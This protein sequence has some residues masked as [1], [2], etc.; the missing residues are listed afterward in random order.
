MQNNGYLDVKQQVKLL[1]KKGI[2]IT[3]QDEEILNKVNYYTIMSYKNIFYVDGIIHQYKKGIS[4]KD[5]YS[6]Y[7]LDNE[8]KD[9]LLKKFRILTNKFSVRLINRFCEYYGYLED[10]YLNDDLYNKMFIKDYYISLLSND[11]V[12]DYYDI[13]GFIPLWIIINNMSFRDLVEYIMSFKANIRVQFELN[14][15]QEILFYSIDVYST[16]FNNVKTYDFTKNDI[17]LN[18]LIMWLENFDVDV[19]DL[20]AKYLEI[21][22]SV[23]CLNSNDVKRVSG[24]EVGDV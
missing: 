15:R 3:N 9:L 17:K 10:A 8:I 13:H 7:V 12:K 2:I 11:T 22:N 24:I 21:V 14:F 23:N 16:I 19:C 6:V 4:L 5:F 18:N 1:R 20:K